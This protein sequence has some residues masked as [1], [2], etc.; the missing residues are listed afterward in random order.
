M[1]GNE[2][3]RS[4]LSGTRSRRDPVVF[5]NA[6]CVG[7]NERGVVPCRGEGRAYMERELERESNSSLPGNE[8]YYTA[9]SLLV[10]FKNSCI[11]LYCQKGFNSILFLYESTL[12]RRGVST[13]SRKGEI[14]LSGVIRKGEHLGV[15]WEIGVSTLSRRGGSTLSGA[16]REGRAPC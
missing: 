11:E 10:I 12:S 15:Q 7:A 9:C 13:L 2:R 16:M 8:V 3:G 14:T 6:S 5:R 1:G 4:T